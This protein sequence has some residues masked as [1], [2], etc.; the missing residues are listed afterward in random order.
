LQNGVTAKREKLRCC[1]AQGF[2][3]LNEEDGLRSPNAL[4]LD[5]RSFRTDWLIQDEGK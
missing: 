5:D 3:I 4:R 1:P 2:L